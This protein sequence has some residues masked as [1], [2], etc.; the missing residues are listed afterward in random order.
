MSDHH[1][2]PSRKQLLREKKSLFFGPK[3]FPSFIPFEVKRFFFLYYTSRNFSLNSWAELPLGIMQRRVRNRTVK[4][5]NSWKTS[6]QTLF[7]DLVTEIFFCQNEKLKKRLL[8]SV[9]STYKLM[10]NSCWRQ[11]TVDQWNA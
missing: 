2:L 6:F 1:K 10:P 7:L 4:R 3:L 11:A 9:M 8:F 5:V